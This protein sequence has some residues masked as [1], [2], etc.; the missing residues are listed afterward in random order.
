MISRVQS[1]LIFLSAGQLINTCSDPGRRV[2]C[3]F[4]LTQTQSDELCLNQ[5]LNLSSTK[6]KTPATVGWIHMINSRLWSFGE[7]N[8]T[9]LQYSCLENPMQGSLAGYSPQGHKESD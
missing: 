9:L 1:R 2:K 4:G 3:S 8:G 6:R 5:K 7:R